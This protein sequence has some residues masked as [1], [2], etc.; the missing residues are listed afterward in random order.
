MEI[1]WTRVDTPED[2]SSNIT[3]YTL[4]NF[5][6]KCII[7]KSILTVNYLDSISV[8]E[9]AA[10]FYIKYKVQYCQQE[11]IISDDENETINKLINQRDV[12][13]HVGLMEYIKTTLNK[14][15]VVFDDIYNLKMD[16]TTKGEMYYTDNRFKDD[17]QSGTY[18]KYFTRP[19][20]A[21]VNAK[22]KT[23]K[24]Y[25][26]D[27]SRIIYEHKSLLAILRTRVKLFLTR[28][29]K[30]NFI[31]L[32]TYSPV[33]IFF[34]EEDTSQTKTISEYVFRLKQSE[35]FITADVIGNLENAI[36][37]WF[38]CFACVAKC[39]LILKIH[40]NN[41]TRSSFIYNPETRTSRIFEF[42]VFETPL[43]KIIDPKDDFIYNDHIHNYKWNVYSKFGLENGNERDLYA[44]CVLFFN[45]AHFA[46]NPSLNK[47]IRWWEYSDDINLYLKFKPLLICL[48]Y[49]EIADVRKLFNAKYTTRPNLFTLFIDIQW[50]TAFFPDII[51]EQENIFGEMETDIQ[52]HPMKTKFEVFR[53]WLLGESSLSRPSINLELGKHVSIM[54]DISYFTDS[55]EITGNDIDNLLPNLKEDEPDFLKNKLQEFLDSKYG[56]N[57]RQRVDSSGV[58]VSDSDDGPFEEISDSE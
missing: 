14:N 44:V 32:N 2:Q 35:Q 21:M 57:K 3:K 42:S 17:V 19:A 1:Q 58:Y 6:H 11:I 43:L 46:E 18:K 23:I 55:T 30:N 54:Q 4:T 29:I 52:P 47:D 16:T 24:T 20:E 12:F 53:K 36:I 9:M 41:L 34:F 33:D 50:I 45:F 39:Q 8:N 48:L 56:N 7:N 31:R 25:T 28:V 22:Y 49:L 13:V 10:N 5:F 26:L 38:Y 15:D 37:T 27:E 51:T 40:L